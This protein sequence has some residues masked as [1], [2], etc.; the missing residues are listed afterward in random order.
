LIF[1]LALA[2]I[3]ADG[4]LVLQPGEAVLFHLDHGRPVLDRT[5]RPDEKIP[6][7]S[8]LAHLTVDTSKGAPDTML[9]IV[10]NTPGFLN[11]KARIS[12]GGTNQAT[13]VCTLMSNGRA[14]FESWPYAI[15]SVALDQFTD[16][17]EKMI[18][19]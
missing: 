2:V 5:V 9:S 7:G 10:N 4:A 16:A 6:A 11:Y 13:S 8:L 12:R 15:D 3:S 19:Q 14:A 1:A 18:C 17:P